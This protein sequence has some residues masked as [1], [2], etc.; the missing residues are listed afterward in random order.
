MEVDLDIHKKVICIEVDLVS[1]DGRKIELGN[2]SWPKQVEF[3]KSVFFQV[4]SVQKISNLKV[5]DKENLNKNQVEAEVIW[6]N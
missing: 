4:E 3:L 5:E 2:K 1:N 6:V